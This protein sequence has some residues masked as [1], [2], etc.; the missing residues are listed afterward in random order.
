V[1]NTSLVLVCSA[2][3]LLAGLAFSAGNDAAPAAAPAA[4]IG[5]ESAGWTA[6]R[7]DLA[8]VHQIKAEAFENSKVMDH[9][10]QLTD[11][12]GPRVT[13][14][15]GYRE[16]VKWCVQQ[17]QEWGL[18]NAG[19]EEFE[20]GK[21]WDFSHFEAHLVEPSYAPLIGFPL[22]WSP[23]TDG[24]VTGEPYHAVLKTEEDLDKHKG[25]LKGK[26][27]LMDEPRE[28]KLS[29]EAIGTRYSEGDLEAR[30]IAAEPR[31]R[32]ERDYRARQKKRTAF[33]AKLFKFLNEE[34]VVAVMR[35]GYKGEAGLVAASRGGSQ[36]TD[37]PTPPP[38]FAVSPEHY[39]RVIRLMKK[40]IPTKIALEV[41]AEFY[42]DDLK[43]QNVIAEIPG[44]T[45]PDEVV[46]LGG[47]LDSWHGG[48][49]AV[50]NAT[51]VA[52]SMEAIRILKKLGLPMDRT[53]RVGLW[54]GEEQGLLGARAYVKAHFADR[55]T[56]ALKPEHQKLAAYYN[57][58][59]GSGKIRGIYLQGNDMLRPVFEAWMKPFNDLGATTVTIRDTGGT[60]HQAFDEVGLPGFQFIQDPLEY[61]KRTH[62][63][64]A[65]V[66]DHVQASDVMQSAA[67]MASMVYHTAVRAEML[68]RKPLPKP[69]P[70]V[71]EKDE[72]DKKKDS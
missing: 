14:S 52:I 8:V 30:A 68:P 43:T 36:K 5:G 31:Q 11:V 33:N 20:F 34:G 64:N 45:K 59:N 72:K 13:N 6:D 18:D 66:Y 12:N 61:S 35:T 37:Q 23:G 51:G 26:I 32:E 57:Y 44:T 41:K 19:T 56:M 15:P 54:A 49:G 16:A 21:G 70:K 55:E 71:E 7:A 48:T 39:N 65:D 9:I 38:M 67:V 25:K 47:H 50:D 58:D 10:F 28:I 69:R 60:D 62:H 22:A 29:S 63:S 1:K 2:I 24:V 46:M 40:E 42:E 3:L 53:V 4:R 27:L 17:L